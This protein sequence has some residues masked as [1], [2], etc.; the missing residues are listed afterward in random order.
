MNQSLL[1][2]QSIIIVLLIASCFAVAQEESNGAQSI[3][4]YSNNTVNKES[5][6][7]T[8]P[9]EVLVD[10]LTFESDVAFQ[11]EE[12]FYLLDFSASCNC[13]C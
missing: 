12:F 4:V 9:Q 11:Q 6:Q 8:F 3:I 13:C 1:W 5:I 10:A 7:H 2:R